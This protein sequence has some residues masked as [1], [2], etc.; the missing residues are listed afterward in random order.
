MSFKSPYQS[1]AEE[2]LVAAGS[3][4]RFGFEWQTYSELRPEYEEQFRRWTSPLAP[5]DWRGTYFLDVGC[6]MGRNSHWPMQY[7]ARGGVS[8]DVD[9]ASLAAARRTLA[10][11]PAVTI[12]R[13]SA[14]DIDYRDHF[15][16]AFSI[17]VVHHLKEPEKA[18]QAMVAAVKP[19]GRVLIWV[20]GYENNRWIVYLVSPLRLLIFSWMPVRMLH[21]VSWV[22]AAVLW[23][24]LRAGFA[25]APYLQLL[26]SFS[27]PH[28]RSI[29]FDQLLPKIAHYWRRETVAA[30]M[31]N[32]GLEEVELVWVNQV[33]WTAIGL[34]PLT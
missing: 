29:V 20:Y 21:G 2:R 4:D 25:R 11:F 7:G 16:I 28:L 34:K 12:R 32:A 23:L 30:M 19:G 1:S 18:L 9:E 10:P 26:K 15:D 8:I 27:F 14:Y 5:A 22:P 3:P 24:M 31:A 13:L 17:G 33:S 6:G